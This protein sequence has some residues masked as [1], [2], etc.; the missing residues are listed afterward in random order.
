MLD[1]DFC[2]FLEYQL[3][4]AFENSDDKTLRGFWCDGI[5][6]PSNENEFSKKSINDNRQVVAMAYLG[7]TGQEKYQLII[8][9]GKKAL[10]RFARDL[11]IKD[12]VPDPETDDWYKVDTEN[13]QIA[14]Q[15]H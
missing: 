6:L 5:V 10:S 4:S 1:D 9:F 7:K 2:N 11:D 13:K 3:T 14:I 15:L 12:C 8:K